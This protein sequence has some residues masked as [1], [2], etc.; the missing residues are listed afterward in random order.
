[1][2]NKQQ[3][4]VK[5][6]YTLLLAKQAAQEARDTAVN[7]AA[8]IYGWSMKPVDRGQV[9]VGTCEFE[10]VRD[11]AGIAYDV[12]IH[13]AEVIYFAAM[14]PAAETYLAA[15]KSAGCPQGKEV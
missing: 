1:M 12:A 10:A 13:E 7:L 14:G 9:I 2:K 15:L 5:P 6:G 8:E 3:A 11:T 4:E